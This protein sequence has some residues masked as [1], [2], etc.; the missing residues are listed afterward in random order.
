[1]VPRKTTPIGCGH[2][3]SGSEVFCTDSTPQAQQPP[4]LVLFGHI[5]RGFTR[6]RQAVYVRL[7]AKKDL[8]ELR[9]A[10]AHGCM[11]RCLPRIIRQINVRPKL[12]Q[13]LTHLRIP[14]PARRHVQRRLPLLALGVR[15]GLLLQQGSHNAE[16]CPPGRLVQRRPPLPVPAV[17]VRPRLHQR[18]AQV[19]RPEPGG[20]LEGILP[21][22]VVLVDGG[23]GADQVLGG[24]QVPVG[25]GE[26][27][28]ALAFAAAADSHG[29]LGMHQHLA[30]RRLPILRRIMQR[31]EP[32]VT[33]HRHIGLVAQQQSTSL[34]M[35]STSGQVQWRHAV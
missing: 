21:L 8:A 16:V 9:I 11:Q 33:R 25:A 20:L 34:R 32:Q 7:L 3:L 23:A 35:P 28:G 13:R 31:G 10:L 17:H 5:Q 19:H 18:P 26:V 6:A 14:E 4:Y 12:H 1:M 29:C 24:F 2:S 15:G 22:P 30:D 27:Q